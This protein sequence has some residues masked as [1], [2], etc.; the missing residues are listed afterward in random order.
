MRF[1]PPTHLV[2]LKERR[3]AAAG[4]PADVLDAD[5]VKSVFDVDCRV[6]PAPETGT[7]LVIPKGTA[8]RHT[9]TAIPAC[10]ARHHSPQQPTARKRTPMGATTSPR[11][12]GRIGAAALTS[13]GSQ[14]SAANDQGN[15]DA[16]S[17]ALPRTVKNAMG[18]V[19]IPA[20][21]KRVVVLDTGELN[22]VTMLGI[23]PVGALSPHM[24][25]EGGFP[26]YLK[27]K[28][29]GV[30]DVG[31]L[32]EPNL[33]WIASLKPDKLRGIA[34]TV[35]TDTTGGPWKA[36]L[37]VHAEALGMK[38]QAADALQSYETQAK[39]LGKA[40]KKNYDGKMSAASV[41]RFGADPMRLHQKS[42]YSGVV[43]NDIG[44]QRPASQSSEDPK[45]TM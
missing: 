40:V 31:P 18:Y 17:G 36:N 32:L 12:T 34:P 9:T 16:A 29:T 6:I 4:V 11:A 5:L 27:D 15:A 20:K 13:C 3:L 10:P 25:T 39:A 14:K 28:T 8:A 19:E 43:L 37:K 33:E 24:K 44:L 38:K 7:P 42:S 26:Q 1:P 2:V 41:V 22:D 35:F 45:V 21:P 30:T 23:T